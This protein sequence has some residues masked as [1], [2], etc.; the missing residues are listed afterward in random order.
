MY[1]FPCNDDLIFLDNGWVFS[2]WDT[3]SNLIYF[4]LGIL[5]VFLTHRDTVRRLEGSSAAEFRATARPLVTP[6]NRMLLYG[7]IIVIGMASTIYH[8][9]LQPWSLC[10]DFFAIKIFALLIIWALGHELP[11]F[12]GYA[13][14]ALGVGALLT[15]GGLLGASALDPEMQQFGTI[16]YNITVTIMM[17]IVYALILYHLTTTGRAAEPGEKWVEKSVHETQARYHARA[18][19]G[20][21]VS[22]VLFAVALVF[23]FAPK[24]ACDDYRGIWFLRLHAYWHVFSGLALFFCVRTISFLYHDAER[25]Q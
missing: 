25:D 17:A 7:W 22:T 20:L 6:W 12:Y 9:T 2:V 8:S 15:T 11:L 3:A 18:R 24:V 21:I 19:R 14:L 23:Y 5:G 1:Y 10:M 13:Y 4:A 16:A